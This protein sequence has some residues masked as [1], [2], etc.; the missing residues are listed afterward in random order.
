[1]DA[2]LE[3]S[4]QS[5]NGLEATIASAVRL[6]GVR[7]NREAF[8]AETFSGTPAG[9][10]EA[11]ITTDPIT[12]GCSQET[13]RKCAMALI[14]KRTMQSSAVSFAAGL[15]GGIAMAATI[16]ADALQF[17]GT[18]LRLA[19]ELSYLYGAEDIWKDGT[20]DDE[21]VRN[22][23]IL[24]CGVMFGVS[25]SSVA[26]KVFSSAVAKQVL[27]TLPQK[28]VAEI[29]LLQ[30]ASKIAKMVGVR[31]TKGLFAKGVSKAI[32]IIGG[33]VSGGITFASMKPMGKRLVDTLEQANFS[34][35]KEDAERDIATLYHTAKEDDAPPASQASA[36][37][38]ADELRSY[39]ALVDEGLLTEDE[40]AEI[41][42]K[43]IQEISSQ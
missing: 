4:S 27:K 28:K 11:I 15:P 29:F 16:P 40:F 37:S 34:Y 41:K 12:A 20:V 31:L 1:M 39:K 7:V 19:Q 21:Q 43:L 38:L 35:T 32:P 5:T 30:T 42:T 6:P 23:L 14:S 2:T 13:L 3:K 9:K 18:T 8:L 25:G 33:V 22:S 10:L 36:P 26:V 17:F 24:Y